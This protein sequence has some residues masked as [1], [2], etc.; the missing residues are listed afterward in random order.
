MQWVKIV[1]R[2]SAGNILGKTP[3]TVAD[4]DVVGSDRINNQMIE[5]YIDSDGT[6]TEM[7]VMDKNIMLLVGATNNNIVKAGDILRWEA[8]QFTM[9]EP[10]SAI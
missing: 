3:F 8:G 2:D 7:A 6:L 1:G 9:R 10:P 4:W 5:I